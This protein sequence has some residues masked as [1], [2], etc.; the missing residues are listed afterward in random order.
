MRVLELLGHEP[1][2]RHDVV[3][4]HLLLPDE[5]GSDM[6]LRAPAMD[7]PSLSRPS[8]LEPGYYLDRYELLCP[9]A[10]GGMA[11][12]WV[13]RL[14]GKHGFEK[15]FAIKTIL[16]QHAADA[17]FQQMFLDEARVASR[18]EHTNVAQILDLG[19]QHD[20]LYIVMEWV[21]GE[22]LSRLYRTAKKKNVAIPQGVLLRIIAD[23]CGGLHAAHELA[24]PDGKSL[25]VVHRDVTPQN[26]LVSAQGVARLI[27]FGIAKA[28]DRIAEDTNAGML[29]GKVHYMAPEQATSGEVDR[30]TDVFGIGAVLYRMLAHKPAFDAQSPQL[31]LQR[32]ASKQPPLPLPSSVHPAVAQLVMRAL[33]LEPRDRFATAAELQ[34]AIE[35]AMVQAKIPTT[36]HDVARFA[37]EHLAEHVK[38]RKQSIE[39]AI[40]AAKERQRIRDAL[41]PAPADTGSQSGVI[42]IGTMA[43]DS[44][45][46]EVEHPSTAKRTAMIAAACAALAVIA[47]V[48][49]VKA[50][51]KE[52]ATKVVVVQAPASASAAAPTE[53]YK[54]ITP[55]AIDDL[56]KPSASVT[57]K[58][59]TAPIV[60]RSTATPVA[61][62][63]GK[64]HRVNDGF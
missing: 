62:T 40:S 48:G 45:L 3:E 16:P 8:P 18:V 26:I 32:Y 41:K 11:S 31:L 44:I 4:Q 19:E 25:N 57:A 64:K 58:T 52:A 38:E 30:R 1:D 2:A 20:I 17:R 22:S 47:T 23:A 24:G 51:R 39:L 13:A 5:H 21:D 42:P 55:V 54:P 59:T 28:R 33:A 34:T 49:I 37:K 53:A 46:I 35:G 9:I 61:T 29:K 27:D 7:T 43:D 36:T 12:V 50:T 10:D 14:Q 56:P 15:L 6:E 60:P 63:A